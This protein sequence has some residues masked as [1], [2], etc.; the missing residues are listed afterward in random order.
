[1]PG[2]PYPHGESVTVL[3]QGVTGA[4]SQNN[5]IYGTVASTIVDGCAVAPRTEDEV[6][7]NGRFGV[8]KGLT[9]YL[10]ADTVIAAVDLVEVAG[11]TYRIDGDP[12]AWRNPYTGRRPGIAI[13]LTRVEG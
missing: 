1:M 6:T 8:V 9:V 3:T 5:P 13:N 4:D 10:P 12:A 7:D 11:L 2:A